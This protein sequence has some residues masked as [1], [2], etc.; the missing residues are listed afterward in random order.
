M[1][2]NRTVQEKVGD[3]YAAYEVI[4]EQIT[5]QEFRPML[6]LMGATDADGITNVQAVNLGVA[7]ARI[8]MA[9]DRAA[10]QVAAMLTTNGVKIV[11]SDPGGYPE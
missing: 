8:V 3:W 10:A 7:V 5:P 1:A 9:N 2:G 6:A 4:R 11:D